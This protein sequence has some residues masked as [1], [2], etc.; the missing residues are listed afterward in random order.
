MATRLSYGPTGSEKSA[1]RPLSSEE[2][3]PPRPIEDDSRRAFEALVFAG[4]QCRN[5]AHCSLSSILSNGTTPHHSK[6]MK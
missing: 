5:C 4:D 2:T 1:M 6:D 3:T